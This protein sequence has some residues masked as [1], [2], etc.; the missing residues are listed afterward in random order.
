[1]LESWATDQIKIGFESRLYVLWA[2]GMVL[3][4]LKD[5]STLEMVF[6]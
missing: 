6:L 4:N 1:M 3:H 2:L 5:S